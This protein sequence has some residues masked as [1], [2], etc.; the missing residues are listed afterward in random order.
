[1]NG[2]NTA[3]KAGA[4]LELDRRESVYTLF[5]Q[6]GVEFRAV[7][8]PP[9]F[10]R[11]DNDR[12]RINFGAAICKN[13][14]LRNR[15]KSGYYLLTLPLDKRAD[16]T[17]VRSL[18]GETR[19]SFGEEDA[20]FDKLNIRSGSVSFLNIIGAPNTDVIFLIDSSVLDQETIGVHPNDNTATVIFSTRDIHKIFDYYG[21]KY[22]F[23]AL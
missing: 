20:L 9:I 21:A 17:V 4:Q 22:R 5:R 6:L 13:L 1:V 2:I 3:I 16:L 18:L 11:A 19:L 14:F 10:T 12:Y 7:D 23:I 15:E 8:H